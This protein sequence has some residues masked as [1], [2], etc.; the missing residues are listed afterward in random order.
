M[1]YGLDGKSLNPKE[2]KRLVSTPH[3]PDRLW[4]HPASYPMGT[5]EALST[6]VKRQGREAD[7]RLQIVSRSRI[8]ELYLCSP[9]RLHGIVLH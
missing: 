1:C 2:A 3:R 7:T 9:I 6:G 5:G 4:A 8:L